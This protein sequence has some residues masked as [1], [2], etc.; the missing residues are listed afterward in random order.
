M[1][2]MFYNCRS[3]E[4]LNLSNFNTNNIKD[5]NKIFWGCSSLKELQMPNSLKNFFIKNLKSEKKIKSCL[6]F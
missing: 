1:N 3:L 4:K 5:K 6:L 2:S